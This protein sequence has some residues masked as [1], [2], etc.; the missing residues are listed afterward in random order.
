M[1]VV[2]VHDRAAGTVARYELDRT[3]TVG[4][5]PGCDV[6][7]PWNNPW[8]PGQVLFMRVAIEG[9]DVRIAETNGLFNLD[10]APIDLTFPHYLR[11]GSRFA[12]GLTLEL[13]I[14]RVPERPANV[15]ALPP[16]IDRSA[17]DGFDA[18]M[19]AIEDAEKRAAEAWAAKRSKDGVLIVNL[20]DIERVL[21]LLH[22]TLDELEAALGIELSEKHSLLPGSVRASLADAAGPL[23]SIHASYRE[24]EL[25]MRGGLR[26]A[27]WI[28]LES[29]MVEWASGRTAWRVQLD[30][31]RPGF[32]ITPVESDGFYVAWSLPDAP[33]IDAETRTRWVETL[34]ASL[35]RSVTVRELDELLASPPAGV[36]VH[37]PRRLAFHPPI[38]FGV[39]SNA[40]RL[41]PYD[42][43][44]DFSDSS[45]LPSWIDHRVGS[46][47][48]YARIDPRDSCVRVLT[49]S[50]PG[51]TLRQ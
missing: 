37:H 17:A 49:V 39:I 5:S 33:P 19:H 18:D 21:A 31:A 38:H 14:E 8:M 23:E 20:P 47:R 16:R 44:T 41:G 27:R 25:E 29:F 26:R 43:K 36:T 4:S 3:F 51:D 15:V 35:R 1:V 34:V 45:Y 9:T 48:V 2:A 12:A 42:L 10:G 50:L 11:A 32:K 13:V 24:D 28:H 22:P 6:P 40:L 30:A 7:V 46:W